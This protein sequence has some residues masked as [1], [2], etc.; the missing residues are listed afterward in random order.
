MSPAWLPQEVMILGVWQ[1]NTNSLGDLVVGKVFGTTLIRGPSKSSCRWLCRYNLTPVDLAVSWQLC[2]HL[3]PVCRRQVPWILSWMVEF[4]FLLSF[5]TVHG[6]DAEK[7]K[8]MLLLTA[9]PIL[10]SSFFCI[11]AHCFHGSS[12]TLSA[13]FVISVAIYFPL[14]PFPFHPVISNHSCMVFIHFNIIN[15]ILWCSSIG[16]G[17]SLTPSSSFLPIQPPNE[18]PYIITIE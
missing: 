2:L 3:A 7:H 16:P 18:F 5:K 17:I 14:S 15:I 10:L 12:C 4:S 13:E 11:L 6:A 8:L 1:L 9:L